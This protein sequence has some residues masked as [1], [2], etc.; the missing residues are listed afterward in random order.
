MLANKHSGCLPNLDRQVDTIRNK[1]WIVKLTNSSPTDITR[2]TS[3]PI[4]I[5]FSSA[6]RWIHNSHGDFKFIQIL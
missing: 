3:R 6:L 2:F 4:T 1:R 5:V